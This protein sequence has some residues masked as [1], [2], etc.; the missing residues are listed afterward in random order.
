M[1][2][3]RN[4]FE[5]IAIEHFENIGDFVT[6]EE[7]YVNYSVDSRDALAEILEKNHYVPFFL[8]TPIPPSEYDALITKVLIYTTTGNTPEHTFT[9][10]EAYE[11]M[12][13]ANVPE[14]TPFS[15]NV[16]ALNCTD[17][18]NRLQSLLNNYLPIARERVEEFRMYKN[19]V[20]TLFEQS[21]YN[22]LIF[23]ELYKEYIQTPEFKDEILPVL[24]RT[25]RQNFIYFYPQ[26]N[27]ICGIV[28]LY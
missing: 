16:R 14:K 10:Y 21:D 13:E 27:E 7:I 17:F 25:L 4:L 1:I 12:I 2:K 26:Q 15:S 24:I 8:D 28:R 9:T 19:T 23:K 20:D 6:A 11:I 3:Y 18:F 22:T 5:K